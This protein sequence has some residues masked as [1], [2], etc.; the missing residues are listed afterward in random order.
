MEE[1]AVVV[2]TLHQFEEVVAVAWRLVEQC[3]TNVAH[4]GFYANDAALVFLFCKGGDA[5]CGKE[6]NEENEK[7]FHRM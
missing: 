6:N 4:G 5:K 7:A 2:S 1:G 3:H